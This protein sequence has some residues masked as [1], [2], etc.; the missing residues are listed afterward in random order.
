MGPEESSRLNITSAEFPR[1]CKV[2]TSGTTYFSAK[3]VDYQVQLIKFKHFKQNKTTIEHHEG[4]AAKLSAAAAAEGV[5]AGRSG[6]HPW[7]LGDWHENVA[8]TFGESFTWWVVPSLLSIC[9]SCGG[10]GGGSKSAGGGCGAEGDGTLY[11]TK[12][13]R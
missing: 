13:D 3:S 6:K 4:V 10:G 12:W 9:C 8:A 7:D 5:G 2:D 11:P 1:R